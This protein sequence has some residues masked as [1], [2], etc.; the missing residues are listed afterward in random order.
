MSRNRSAW[1]IHAIWKRG[2]TVIFDS[3][4]SLLIAQPCL[5]SD[6]TSSRHRRMTESDPKRTPTT[7]LIYVCDW[8]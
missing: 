2:P 6:R 3:G 8:S 4:A 5:L 1:P 7:Q